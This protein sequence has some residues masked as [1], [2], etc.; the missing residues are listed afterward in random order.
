MIYF[1]PAFNQY[2]VK[3]TM[4]KC[5]GSLPTP[6]VTQH[7]GNNGNSNILPQELLLSIM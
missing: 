2:Y 5:P 4:I 3:A 1:H 6:M 7:G